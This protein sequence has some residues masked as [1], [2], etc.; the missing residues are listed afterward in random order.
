MRA[1][2]IRGR[3]NL[4]AGSVFGQANG[5]LVLLIIIIVRD[6]TVC[7]FSAIEFLTVA[8]SGLFVVR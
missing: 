2:G 8:R 4:I 3:A 7:L 1:G 6:L 5:A